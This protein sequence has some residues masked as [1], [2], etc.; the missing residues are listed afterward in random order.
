MHAEVARAV[1]TRVEMAR[2]LGVSVG[3][4]RRLLAE[5]RARDERREKEPYVTLV[6]NGDRPAR[7][8]W[9]DLDTDQCSVECGR[10]RVPDRSGFLGNQTPGGSQRM[11]RRPLEGQRI[12]TRD[13]NEMKVLKASPKKPPA[14]FRPR[15]KRKHKLLPRPDNDMQVC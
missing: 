13:V 10:V 9:Y 7:G 15:A 5:E 14:K 12:T 1:E 6:A 3:H 8:E 4:L 11:P 2:R